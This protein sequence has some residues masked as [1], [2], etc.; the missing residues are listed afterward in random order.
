MTNENQEFKTV[1]KKK[2][3]DMRDLFLQGLEGGIIQK[4]MMT[5][6]T[7]DEI[8]GAIKFYSYAHGGGYDLQR[9]GKL[10]QEKSIS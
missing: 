10:F 9:F 6:F 7:E 4:K 2:F 5:T 8:D 1:F 3:K